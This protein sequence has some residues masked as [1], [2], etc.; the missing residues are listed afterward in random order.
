MSNVEATRAG[1]IGRTKKK[2]KPKFQIPGMA[3]LIWDGDSPPIGT[4]MSVADFL[5]WIDEHQI[6]L[7]NRHLIDA[8]LPMSLKRHQK[9]RANA[10][11]HRKQRL[12]ERDPDRY[13]ARKKAGEEL[14]DD[15]DMLY[16]YGPPTQKQLA[17]LRKL[18]YVGDAPMHTVA[19]AAL[20]DR[21]LKQQR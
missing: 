15:A 18:N 20:I 19:A 5:A 13:L 4:V 2:S 16:I 17:L 11:E 1:V 7:S 21:L 14:F 9:V 6:N 10:I 8:T 12:L 3:P